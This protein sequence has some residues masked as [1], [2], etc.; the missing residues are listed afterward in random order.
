VLRI[1]EAFHDWYFLALVKL[2]R[3]SAFHDW[4]RLPA[5]APAAL[6]TG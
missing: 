2:S 3:S 1:G 5:A 6:S 4:Y